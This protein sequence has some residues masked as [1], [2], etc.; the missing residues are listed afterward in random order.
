MRAGLD[1]L[2]RVDELVGRPNL[3]GRDDALDFG[4]HDRND[5]ERDPHA[6]HLADHPLLH[7]LGLDLA[8]PRL[9]GDAARFGRHQYAGGPQHRIDHVARPQDEL[10]DPAVD[11]GVH[12]GLGQ[13]D[14]GLLECCLGAG[15]LGR[16]LK[17]DLGD[18]G[19]LV[20]ERGVDQPLLGIDLRS[21]RVRPRVP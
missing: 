18:H 9:D 20:G 12:G 16:Q 19:L 7:H 4:H 14:L 13:R 2:H 15:L 1:C 8:E 3:P 17:V 5:R 6:G 21:A 10:L 11:A